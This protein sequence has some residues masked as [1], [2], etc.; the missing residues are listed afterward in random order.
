MVWVST[1]LRK[2]DLSQPGG[3][4]L[5]Q[6]PMKVAWLLVATSSPLVMND[7]RKARFG[8]HGFWGQPWGFKALLV[9]QKFSIGRGT[10][11]I[12]TM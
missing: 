2:P 9:D 5:P 8:A 3:W 7:R 11:F 1:L 10:L 12:M 4:A 6:I